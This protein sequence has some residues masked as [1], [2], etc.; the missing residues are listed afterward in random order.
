MT[1]ASCVQVCVKSFRKRNETWNEGKKKK[2]WALFGGGYTAAQFG[3][4]IGKW[5]R[6]SLNECGS[7]LVTGGSF[8][9]V[10]SKYIDNE[11]G[12]DIHPVASLH[13]LTAPLASYRNCMIFKHPVKCFTKNQQFCKFESFSFFFNLKQFI[14]F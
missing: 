2:G 7:F 1:E 9:E 4:K 14:D 10:I 8:W 11:T 5:S 12:H 13:R 6:E 3:S